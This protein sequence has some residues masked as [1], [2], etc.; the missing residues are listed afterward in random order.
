MKMADEPKTETAGSSAAT[1]LAVG[2]GA[3]LGAALLA[4][5]APVLLPIVG[6][7]ALAGLAVPVVGATLG[8][9]A[10]YAWG[11]KK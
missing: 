8:G 10:G 6:L 5:A 7:G 3:V 9:W 4:V 11:G 2:G 1:A